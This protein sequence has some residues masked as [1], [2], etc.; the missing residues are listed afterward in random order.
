MTTTREAGEYILGTDR[1]ELERLRLQHAV[2]SAPQHELM[3]VAGLRAGERVLDLG[4][5]PGFT[6]F[7]LAQ[8]VG[9]SGRVVASDLS[10][11]F[12]A[13]LAHES[14]RLGLGWID[15]VVGPIEELTLPAGS[16]D[17]AYGRWIFCW[18]A[19][20]LAALER[21]RAALRP[22][23]RLLVQEYL[24]WSTM[25]AYPT[26][27]AC[28]RMVEAGLAN[29][30]AASIEIDFA[31]RLPELAPRAG[32]ALEHFR[33]RARLGRVGSMEWRWIGEFYRVYYPKLVERGL[34]GAHEFA[35]WQEDWARREREGA[36]WLATPT[37]ADVVLRKL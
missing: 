14:A 13:F 28:L 32:F 35:A 16:F 3:D 6:T 4:S 10:A 8:R 18:L 17:A 19:D 29:W 27:P 1:E 21:V 31:A 11:R 33:P 7:E 12:L 15:T 25:R 26:S 23:A 37:M 24:N 2:W 5:G 36:S 9:P 20:P 30:R 22:G 34:L